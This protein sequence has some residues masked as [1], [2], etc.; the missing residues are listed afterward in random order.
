MANT[1]ATDVANTI[2][3][4]VSTLLTKTLIQESVGLAVSG[5]WDRSNEV[6]PGMDRLD[7]IE[8]AEL[9]IQS[10]DETGAAMTPQTLVPSAA[11]LLLD[12]HEA[13]PFAITE[14]GLLQ[15]KIALVSNTIEN[16]VRT[17]AAAVDDAI[18]AEAVLAAG[19]T[20]TVAGTD[21]LDEI[22]A[23]K[24]QFDGDNVPRMGRAIIG[25][26]VWI[27]RLLGTNNVIRAN[28]FGNNEA[29]KMG[30]LT[31]VYGFDIFESSSSD[32]PAD[33]FIAMGQESVA[34]AR[35]KA[36]TFREQFFVLN[37]KTDYALVHLYGVKSTAASNK[38]I[39]NFDPV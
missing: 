6:G 8:L 14:K 36:L 9:A 34:F 24:E 38:R 16:G 27:R 33:G 18:F 25:S 30:R 28:E 20:N 3:K 2:E 35:Q 23:C 10:V 13:I 29:I 21:A 12:Q 19:T 31:S 7:M 15:S 22:L 39:F 32:V 5:V 17:M 11:Q 4:K 37:Q 26:P 1:G